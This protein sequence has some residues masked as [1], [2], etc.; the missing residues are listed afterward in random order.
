MDKQAEEPKI[1]FYQDSIS[2]YSELHKVLKL[3]DKKSGYDKVVTSIVNPLRPREFTDKAIK[4]RHQQ[5]T[6][7]DLIL[8]SNEWYSRFIFKITESIDCD[9]QD[10]S[11]RIRS[12]QT[13]AQELSLAEHYNTGN[14]LVK[15]KSGNNVNLA[16]LLSKSI[17]GNIHNHN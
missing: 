11:V 4:V 5:F 2:D 8:T 6:R 3:Y 12:E 15:L 9:S 16:R 14:I 17:R 1:Y 10:D 13:L 7:S